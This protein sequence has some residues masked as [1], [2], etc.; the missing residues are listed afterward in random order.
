MIGEKCFVACKVRFQNVIDRLGPTQS[1]WRGE[2]AGYPRCQL[3][4]HAKPF[5]QN[6][7]RQMHERP[8]LTERAFSNEVLGVEPLFPGYLCSPIRRSQA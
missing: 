5:W 8:L 7:F 4:S 6:H 3:E 1:N 2:R